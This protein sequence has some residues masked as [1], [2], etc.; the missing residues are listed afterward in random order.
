MPSIAR[1]GGFIERTLDL[2][3]VLTRLPSRVTWMKNC[4]GPGGPTWAGEESPSKVMGC[5]INKITE[6]TM[7]A[8]DIDFFDGINLQGEDIFPLA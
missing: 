8:Y 3:M 5:N 6:Q 2:G 1:F 7:A 4:P